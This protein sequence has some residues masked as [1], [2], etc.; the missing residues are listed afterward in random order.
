MVLQLLRERLWNLYRSLRGRDWL[1]F[2]LMRADWPG[3]AKGLV[4]ATLAMLVSWAIAA[5]I[6]KVPHVARA[7]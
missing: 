3:I 4:V 1:Q 7:V 2:L 5:T 6:R